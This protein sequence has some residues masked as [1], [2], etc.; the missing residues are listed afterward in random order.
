MLPSFLALLLL[1]S[2]PKK[3][4]LGFP[5]PFGFYITKP[6]AAEP[7]RG[8]I[9]SAARTT[10]LACRKEV[11]PNQEP[12]HSPKLPR[13]QKDHTIQ[14]IHPSGTPPGTRLYFPERTTK[15]IWG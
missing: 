14:T 4:L 2:L 10:T 15:K 13:E 3:H 9:F 12:A 7:A 8:D 6:A 5:D 11:E 1:G